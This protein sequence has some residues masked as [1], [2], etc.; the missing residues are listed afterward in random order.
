[1]PPVRHQRRQR[2]TGDPAEANEPE[3][4]DAIEPEAAAERKEGR[5]FSNGLSAKRSLLRTLIQDDLRHKAGDDNITMKWVSPEYANAVVIRGAM[6]LVG[7]PNGKADGVPFGNL[8]DV[9]GG[10][11]VMQ[12]LLDLWAS[13][14]LRFEPADAAHI[15]LARRNP[16]AVL[17]GTPP[18]LPAPRCWGRCGRNDMGRAHGRDPSG[19]NPR[20]GRAYRR[21][22]DGPKTPKIYLGSDVDEAD[23]VDSDVGAE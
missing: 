6:R 18:T 20:T 22:R 15:E 14:V 8:S 12:R 23:E 21:R 2:N 4:K 3:A 9:P 11:P 7:W 5:V 19:I 16:R 10:Q 13:G 17:P 1:M